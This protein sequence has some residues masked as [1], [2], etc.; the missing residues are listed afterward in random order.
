MTA[1]PTD[2]ETSPLNAS[3]IEFLAC[4][5]CHAPMQADEDGKVCRCKGIKTHCFDFSRTGYLHLGGPHAGEGD[6][7]E[8]VL[9][10]RSF[11]ES[12]YYQKLA[13]KVCDLLHVI[14]SNRVL[15][16]GCGEGYYTNQMAQE[17]DV[18]GIDLSR[19]GIDYAARSAKQ[20]GNRAGFAVASIFSLPVADQ[21]VDVVTNLFAPC[22]EQEFCRVLKPKGHL[23][24]VGAGERHLLG[25]K[26]LLYENPYTNSGRA[27]LPEKMKLIE[28][29]RLQ[30]EITVVGKGKIEALF[31]MTPYYW[32]TSR[33]DRTKLETVEEL[34]TELDFDIFLFRKDN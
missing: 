10:R 34:T 25:L 12:G 32:R 9:A 4:P 6:S 21:S 17:S 26:K 19:A 3:V 2:K 11:L 28:H 14:P 5:V 30:D 1:E 18:L 29:I 7:K 33:E 22:A 15:D 20:Q 8:A 24:L 27:D 23:L 31:S 13:D 16:A